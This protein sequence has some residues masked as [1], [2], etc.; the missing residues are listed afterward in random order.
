MSYT[1][2]TWTEEQGFGEPIKRTR[3]ESKREL[4]ITGGSPC[5]LE[6]ELS[7]DMDTI[8]LALDERQGRIDALSVKKP[9]NTTSDKSFNVG[10]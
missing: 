5:G 2:K 9:T 1:V 8:K 6:E 4:T 3:T 7:Y 10:F